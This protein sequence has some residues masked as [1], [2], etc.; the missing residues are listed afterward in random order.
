MPTSGLNPR[1]KRPGDRRALPRPGRPGGA[2]WYVL[3]FLMLMALAQVWFL[4]PAGR[5]T[6]AR[7][8]VR[9]SPVSSRLLQGNIGEEILGLEVTPDEP[10]LPAE[11]ISAFRPLPSA[12]LLAAL[13]SKDA[14][15]GLRAALSQGIGA[16]VAQLG[17][18]NGF[19]DDPKVAIPLPPSC[20]TSSA[21]SSIVSVRS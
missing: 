5:D 16:A 7:L 19:L 2:V 12:L 15:G 11:A 20:V 21:V 18:N 14:A 6:L 4:P 17:A 3:G 9:I 8:L 13:S 10:S 1:D